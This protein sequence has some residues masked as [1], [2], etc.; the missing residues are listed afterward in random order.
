MF[1]AAFLA[2]VCSFVMICVVL[3]TQQWMS[4]RVRFSSNSSVIVSL[5]YGLFSG[6]CEQ[7]VEAGLQVSE[8][9]FQGEWGD[10]WGWMVAS[11]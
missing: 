5:T 1:A 11:C 7:F 2:C 8:S 3:A 10:T 9:T 4:S 6:T